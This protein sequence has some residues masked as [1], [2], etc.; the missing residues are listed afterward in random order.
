MLVEKFGDIVIS[1]NTDGLLLYHEES[2]DSQSIIDEWVDTTKFVMESTPYQS[3]YRQNISSYIAIKPDGK[4]KAKGMF[5]DEGM[6][7]NPVNRV[8]INAVRD[9]LQKGTPVEQ[10]IWACNDVR[11]FLTLRTVNGSAVKDGQVLGKSVRWYYSKYS[12]TPILYKTSGNTVP[13]SEG[14]VPLMD[15]DGSIPEDLD[16]S[17]YVR[18]AEDI[19]D[20]IGA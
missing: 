6:M 10:T 1:A 9:Y 12:F 5:A 18:E 19:L 11:D 7:K 14:A 20:S 3:Y 16:R 13:R 8:C 4:I 15:L 2:F 17:W